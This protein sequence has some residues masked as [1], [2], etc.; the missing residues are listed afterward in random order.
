MTRARNTAAALLVVTG[1]LSACSG[2]TPS[3]SPTAPPG[4]AAPT[5]TPSP[6]VPTPTPTPIATPTPR[7]S[8]ASCP[9]APTA[10]SSLPVLWRG[11]NPDDLSVTPGGQLWVSDV[12]AGMVHLV[13]VAVP[14]GQVDRTITGLTTP[15]GIA[16]LANGAVAVGEQDRNRVTVVDTG[17]ARSVLL[18]LPSRGG[19]LGL[20]GITWDSGPANRLLIPDSPH[21]T[22]LS[23]AFDQKTSTMLASGLGRVVGVATGSGGGDLWLAAEAESPR[24]LLHFVN[25]VATPAGHLA[26]LDDVVLDG[27]LL[28]VTDLRN[29]SVHAVDPDSGADRVIATGF[30]EPQGLAVLPDGGL[31]IADSPRGVV[32]R[33][34]PCAA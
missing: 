30:G 5:A 13:D 27:G 22:L 7:A 8:L 6:A 28:Y 33:I 23:Y 19:L 26:Q 9:A 18:T 12:S 1:L 29:H 17:G 32:Q 2:S 25:G 21:G 3:P 16:G 15:D 10:A 34:T 11:G 4:T 31:A 14:G 24:G 20:D